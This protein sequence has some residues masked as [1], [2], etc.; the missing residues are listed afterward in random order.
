MALN[1]GAPWHWASFDRFLNEGLARAWLPLDRWM[2]EFL[3]RRG[4]WLDR[5]NW[6]ATRTHLRRLALESDASPAPAGLVRLVLAP[7][8][9][10][11]PAMRGDIPGRG[12]GP[13]Y[14]GR[15]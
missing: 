6:L 13:G 15:L 3:R 4:Q 7:G 14:W 8:R 11:L 9:V 12:Y 5:T 10:R 1:P 2:R